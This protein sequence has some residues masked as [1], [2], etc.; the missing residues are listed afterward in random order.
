MFF[1]GKLLALMPF[2]N[3]L[4]GPFGKLIIGGAIVAVM[5]LGFMIWLA[6]HD[7]DIRKIATLEFN[8]AQLEQVIKNQKEFDAQLKGLRDD[9]QFVLADILEQRNALQTKTDE[10]VKRINGG[11]FEGGESSDVLR[12]AV[13]ELQRRLD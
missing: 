12:E 11:E 5:V 7:A 6:T 9:E 1:I 3:F 10:L 8:Q 4:R 2:G 13:S